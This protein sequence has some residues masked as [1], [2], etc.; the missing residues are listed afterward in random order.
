[1]Y[2]IASLFVLVAISLVVTRAATVILVATGMSR[3][4]ARCQA[5]SALTGTGFTTSESEPVVDHPVR[6]RVVMMLMLL[7]NVGLVA[8]AGT[9]I[10]G[11]RGGAAGPEWS[12]IVGLVV[13]LL[14]LVFVTRSAWIDRRLTQATSRLLARFTTLPQRDV[15]SLLDVADDYAV[16]ELAVQPGDCLA[17]R[18]LGELD[19]RPAGLEGHRRHADAAAGERRRRARHATGQSGRAEGAYTPARADRR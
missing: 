2:A 1:V 17:G 16:A 15:D 7:G 5:R 9:L 12:R 14:L 4:A 18:T 19:R 3:Q 6:R 13:G 8:V 10:L 11:F